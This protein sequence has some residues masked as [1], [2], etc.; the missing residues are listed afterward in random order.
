M[1]YQ[2]RRNIKKTIEIGV[3]VED[4]SIEETNRFYKLFQ[5][6]EE[7]HGFHFMNEDYFLTECKKYIKIRQC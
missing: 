5:M 7:K 3:K 6:A 1:E 2:T 4:L